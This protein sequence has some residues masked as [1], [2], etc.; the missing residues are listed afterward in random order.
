[1][2]DMDLSHCGYR[3]LVMGKCKWQLMMILKPSGKQPYYEA[4]S[5]LLFRCWNCI[6]GSTGPIFMVETSLCKAPYVDVHELWL[7]H[8]M[9]DQQWLMA[10]R[11]SHK[12]IHNLQISPV[13]CRPVLLFSTAAKGKN[14]L[15]K[16]A[17]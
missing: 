12:R 1:M 5:L 6:M 11:R 3:Y 2:G 4:V 13:H 14:Y 15:I 8:D 16:A 17:T 10:E 9:H 7:V